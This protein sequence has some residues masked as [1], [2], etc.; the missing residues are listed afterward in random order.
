MSDQPQPHFS[1]TQSFYLFLGLNLLNVT[2]NNNKCKRNLD[3]TFINSRPL[4]GNHDQKEMDLSFAG[5]GYPNT[6]KINRS[7]PLDLL[8][9]KPVY[10]IEAI[11]LVAA[12]F[13]DA[14]FASCP[15][16]NIK[17]AF[18][19]GLRINKIKNGIIKEKIKSLW[20]NKTINQLNRLLKD[21][22]EWWTGTIM[23]YA[24]LIMRS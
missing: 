4:A 23:I 2:N 11:P 5:S 18:K 16:N 6:V 3:T 22:S 13:W 10:I 12:L 9:L 19:L 14:K 20:T 21:N 24:P 8:N 15:W 7:W 17:L 1:F